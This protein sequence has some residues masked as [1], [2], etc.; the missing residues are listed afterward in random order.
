M[1]FY[2]IFAKAMVNQTLHITLP[3]LGEYSNLPKFFNCISKQSY[4]RYKV[5]VCVNQYESWWGAS[6]K[7]HYCTDNAKSLA[8]LRSLNLEIEIIDRSS[9]GLGW[10][11]KKGGVGWAR[12]VLMDRISK[13]DKH[14]IIVSMDADTFYP[15]NY[16]FS[17]S[18]YFNK[19]PQNLAL[20][21][22]YYHPL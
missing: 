20:T 5:Y 8:Y 22:P 11:E 16:L 6:D 4:K 9:Q 3:V 19:H 21:I 13:E 15:E 7:V 18:N 14:D 1:E 17:I 10:P 2:A 12:K